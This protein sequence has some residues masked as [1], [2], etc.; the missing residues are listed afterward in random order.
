MFIA[1]QH[2]SYDF[3]VNC[4]ESCNVSCCACALLL[5]VTSNVIISRYDDDV[6]SSNTIGVKVDGRYL[7]FFDPFDNDAA[8]V[9]ID[10]RGH[11]SR[12]STRIDSSGKHKHDETRLM[13]LGLATLRH[14]VCNATNKHVI[15]SNVMRTELAAT[16]ATENELLWD[17]TKLIQRTQQTA[18]FCVFG[19]IEQWIEYT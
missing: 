7:F 4:G 14:I 3:K 19:S 12:F 11:L 18:H 16:A 15:I 2:V 6:H 17:E 1:E 5:S 10:A 8:R 13:K 9:L